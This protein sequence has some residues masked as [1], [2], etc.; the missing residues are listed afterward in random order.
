[1]SVL[2]TKTNMQVKRVSYL[3]SVGTF[4]WFQECLDCLMSPCDL[5]GGHS[6]SHHPHRTTY[7]CSAYTLNQNISIFGVLIVFM[8]FFIYIYSKYMYPVGKEH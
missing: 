4:R 8:L 1:M 2:F 6:S 5:V 7:D 3:L